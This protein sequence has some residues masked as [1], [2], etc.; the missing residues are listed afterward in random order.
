MGAHVLTLTEW[1]SILLKEG[2]R[3]RRRD[4]YVKGEFLIG[5]IV[6][7]L[8]IAE[9]TKKGVEE[10]GEMEFIW[11]NVANGRKAAVQHVI[12]TFEA[13]GFFYCDQAVRFFDNANDGAVAFRIRAV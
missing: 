10:I 2:E 3:S 13:A 6:D 5:T 1:R 4:N 12:D 9:G 11:T 7:V 8:E